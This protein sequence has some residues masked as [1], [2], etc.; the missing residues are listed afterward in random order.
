MLAYCVQ[1]A[2]V[3]DVEKRRNPSKH[4]VYIINV[5]WS[6]STS[7]TIYRRYSKFFDLQMQLLDKFPIEGGQKDPKQRIIPFLPGKILFRRSHIRDVA[8]K[9]LKPID[10]YCRALVRLPPH[11][12]QCDEVFRFFEARPEDVNPPKEDYGSSKRKSG[13][14][15]NAEPMI[16]EQYVVVSNYKKQENS[17]LSLQAGEV[18]DVIEKNESGECPDGRP[19]SWDGQTA[20]RQH[21]AWWWKNVSPAPGK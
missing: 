8:V 2:T 3:V 20:G 9:R 21:F 4:Y 5:T 17:E 7:Q 10:E 13:A 19:G 1:D 12:S 11:I 15:T 14:D 6:D 18:V 16:L